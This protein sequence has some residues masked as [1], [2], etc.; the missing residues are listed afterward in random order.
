MN[1]IILHKGKD[2]AAWQLHPWVFSGAVN[3]IIG[4]IQPGEVVSVYN[5]DDEF[6]AYGVYN[7]TSRVAVRLLE[8]NPAN[9]IDEQWWRMRVKKAVQ[10]REHLLGGDNDSVRLIFAEADF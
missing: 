8:W 4:P 6:I 7:N 9:Q 3:K 10:N 5:I 1:K 2:K